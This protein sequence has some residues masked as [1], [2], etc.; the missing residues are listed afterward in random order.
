V[1]VHGR[2]R[3]RNGRGWTESAGGGTLAWMHTP[4]ALRDAEAAVLQRIAAAPGVFCFLD[5]DGTLAPLAATPDA[6]L[7]APQA[8]A[9]LHQLAAAPG[10]QVAVVTGRTIEDVRTLLAI[11]GI[12]YVGIHGLETRFPDGTAERRGAAGLTDLLVSIRSEVEGT[13][14]TRPGV[15]IEDKGLAL[16]F[17]YR[18]AARDDALAVRR[19]V[20]AAAESHQRRGAPLAVMH[21]H[22]VIEIRPTAANKGRAVCRLLSAQP[23]PTLAVYIG[24]DQTD[25][26]AFTLLPADAITIRVGPATVSTAARYRVERPD[27]VYAFLRA[28]I[29]RRCA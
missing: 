6:A 7:P 25:E 5:Y 14:G 21:G 24:D 28:V 2:R 17:H 27:D 4:V 29:E 1:P 10:V 26:D 20:N 13:L 12:Y 3:N 8:K 11:D 18:L 23:R 15:L 9:L 22:E 19:A 16:A